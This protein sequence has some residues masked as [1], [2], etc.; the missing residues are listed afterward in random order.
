[1][2]ADDKA[3]SLIPAD[4]INDYSFILP[5]RLK[6]IINMTTQGYPYY[7]ALFFGGGAIQHG[8]MVMGGHDPT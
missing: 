7:I 1:M 6:K 2:D 8:G 5:M 4:P 3:S